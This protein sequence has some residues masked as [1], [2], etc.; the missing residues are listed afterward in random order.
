MSPDT[1]CKGGPGH[2]VE[3]GGGGPFEYI[4]EA[5]LITAVAAIVGAEIYVRSVE[6]RSTLSR[7]IMDSIP[8]RYRVSCWSIK[9]RLLGSGL[10]QP[11]PAGTIQ[12]FHGKT[13]KLAGNDPSD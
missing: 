10:D 7:L 13:S 4:D 3:Y 11:L 12:S 8:L 6:I 9:A 5:G 1:E 2:P